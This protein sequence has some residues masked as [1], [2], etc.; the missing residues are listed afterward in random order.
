MT[1]AETINEDIPAPLRAA[2]D[3]A[4]LTT[5]EGAFDYGGGD[6]LRKP[7]LRHRRR[8]RVELRDEDGASHVLFLKRYGPGSLWRRLKRWWITGAWGAM[9]PIEYENVRAVRQAGIPTMTELACGA[10]ES[11]RSF[12][13]VSAVDGVSLENRA[14]DF[15]IRQQDDPGRLAE[16]NS[17][18]ARLMSD[19]HGAGFVHRDFYA[20]HVF[21]D[22]RDGAMDL[23]L[24]DLAR[25]FRPRWRARRWR[26][27]DL[28]QLKYSMPDRWVQQC[29]SEFFNDYLGSDAIESVARPI[30]RAVDRRV[31]RMQRRHRPE[32]FL[33]EPSTY[34]QRSPSKRT[35]R[36][37]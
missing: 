8:T 19:F 27:K 17:A 37:D 34:A 23:S 16:F 24:I 14:E 12:V 21:I 7:G 26:V 1:M 30:E 25:V 10:D 5:V 36:D 31:R 13:L 15:F 32:P 33:Y 20:C 11:G 6:D 35:R 3:E 9:G 18:L 4:G 29:W 22:E 28:A 2:I